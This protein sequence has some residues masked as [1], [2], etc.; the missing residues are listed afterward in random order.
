MINL[1]YRLTLNSLKS[2]N[3]L[4]KVID[5][6]QQRSLNQRSQKHGVFVWVVWEIY[7]WVV[8]EGVEGKTNSYKKSQGL[9]AQID[10]KDKAIDT[11]VYILIKSNDEEI[12]IIENI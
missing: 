8:S 2:H 5:A 7:R 6:A 4:N 10:T 1:L 12:L 11:M 3:N 9:K